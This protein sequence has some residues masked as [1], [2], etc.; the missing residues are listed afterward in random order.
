M[1]HPPDVYALTHMREWIQWDHYVP[2]A[3]MDEK[4]LN[5]LET[6]TY[7]FP[8]PYLAYRLAKALA[9]NNRPEKASLWLIRICKFVPEEECLLLRKSWEAEAG[10]NVLLATIV[11]PQP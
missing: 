7:A 10:N 9:L 8:S 11:W 2:H 1:G 3:G 6:A 5:E 4:A